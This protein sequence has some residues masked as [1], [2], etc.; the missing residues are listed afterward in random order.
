[1]VLLKSVKPFKNVNE[2]FTDIQATTSANFYSLMIPM[3]NA[4]PSARGEPRQTEMK[5]GRVAESLKLRY[6]SDSPD[7]NLCAY[8]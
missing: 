1:M 4:T 7:L 5:V 3:F 2:T 6:Q 8:S